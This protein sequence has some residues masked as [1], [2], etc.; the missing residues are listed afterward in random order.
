MGSISFLEQVSDTCDRCGIRRRFACMRC[1]GCPLGC[2]WCV[3]CCVAT[4]LLGPVLAITRDGGSPWRVV[5][6]NV[7]KYVLMAVRAEAK[8][9]GKKRVLEIIL[10]GKAYGFRSVFTAMWRE[11]GRDGSAPFETILDFVVGY[12][13]EVLR[14]MVSRDCLVLHSMT[15]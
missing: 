8:A 11:Q 9:L 13:E 4:R 12:P 2:D 5:G 7:Q 1:T 15:V 10:V 6:K 14:A 3:E